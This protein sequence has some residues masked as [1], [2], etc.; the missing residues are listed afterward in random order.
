MVS[1]L[2]TALAVS[3]QERLDLVPSLVGDLSAPDHTSVCL[4]WLPSPYGI[5]QPQPLVRH[6]L[7]ELLDVDKFMVIA[8]AGNLSLE[9]EHSLTDT[10]VITDIRPVF[11]EE[12]PKASPRGAVIVHTLKI[13]YRANNEV[14]EFFVTLDDNDVSELSEQLERASSKA[15]SL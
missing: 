3:R 15:E 13:R 9:N 4:P 1:P 6:G 5:T 12:N 11:E 10:R 7:A 14:R 2:S 8:R